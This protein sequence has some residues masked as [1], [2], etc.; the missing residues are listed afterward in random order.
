MS[1]SK[2]TPRPQLVLETLSNPTRRAILAELSQH[3]E[4]SITLNE[5]TE[6]LTQ[7]TLPPK[8][9]TQAEQETLLIDLH[10]N[11]LPKLDN[12]NII[13][14]DPRS[15]TLRYLQDDRIETLLHTIESELS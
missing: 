6:R 11:H 12:A 4:P 10:H 2:K 15:H 9:N 3:N 5:L 14:Y 13:D 7:T 1:Y 8:E